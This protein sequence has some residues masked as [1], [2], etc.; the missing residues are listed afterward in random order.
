MAAR[1]RKGGCFWSLATF[2]TSLE[3]W[4]KLVQCQMKERTGEVATVTI[5]VVR[6]NA[7]TQVEKVRNIGPVISNLPALGL[8]GCG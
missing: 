7:A 8:F 3:G 1:L 5:I 2:R 6:N 4:P